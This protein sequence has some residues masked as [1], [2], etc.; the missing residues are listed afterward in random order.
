MANTIFKYPLD[1]LG[2]S[3]NNKVVG[4]AHTIGTRV[5]RI[6]VADYGPFFGNSAVFIDAATGAELKPVLD[7]RLVHKYKEASDRAGQAVYTAVQIVNPD[8]S[9]EILASVQYVGGEFSYSYYAIQ[10][11]IEALLNDNRQVNWGDLVGV[12]A[13]FAAAPHLHDVY[14]L[15]GMKYLVESEY[16]IAAAIREGDGASRTLLL[17]QLS[18]R[19]TYWNGVIQGMRDSV[20]PIVRETI[21]IPAGGTVNYNMKTLLGT[22]YLEWDMM[23]ARITTRVQNPNS[24]SPT[25]NMMINTENVLTQAITPEGKI[26]L[27]NY[28]T[29]PLEFFVRVDV[30]R[31]S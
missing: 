13:M 18:D 2:N 26:T 12:P 7:Y 29:T 10:Q 30:P 22:G 8:V 9:T 19:D 28:F 3:I 6:F 23:A 1:L 21:T 24:A 25:F 16:D 5:G 15:Y 20:K 31:A 17:K 4:E 27:V 14:D 11:A